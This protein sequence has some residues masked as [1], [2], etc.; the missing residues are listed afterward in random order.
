M[1]ISGVS[2]SSFKVFEE[3]QQKFFIEQSLKYRFPSEWKATDIGTIFHAVAEALALIK[4]SIQNDSPVIEMQELGGIWNIPD[5]FNDKASIHIENLTK[6][7]YNYYT[8]KIM[9]DKQ[10][11]KKDYKTICKYVNSALNDYNGE[12]NPL[13]MDIIAS[14]ARFDI[15]LEN[16]EH[17]FVIRGVIDLIYQGLEKDTIHVLDWKSGS[18]KDFVTQK[19]K[20][21]EDFLEDIQ[22]CIYHWAVS[23]LFPEYEHIEVT[24]FY[25][26]DGGPFTVFFDRSDLDKTEKRLYNRYDEIQKLKIPRLNKSWR[27]EKFCPFSKNFFP[28]PLT[29]FRHGKFT[30][31]GKPMSMCQEIEYVVKENGMEWVELNYRKPQEENKQ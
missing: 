26:K 1:N 12:Y 30:K 16:T 21:Y 24:I 8:T 31:A 25:L 22:L 17:P 7:I 3:C 10:W 14:E 29:E 6:E 19:V 4:L 15:N 13:Q 23:S 20:E 5:D 2:P 18:R 11:D 27:C 9:A 28:E